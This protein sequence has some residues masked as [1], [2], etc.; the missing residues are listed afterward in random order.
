MARTIGWV[1]APADG[2]PPDRMDAY[3]VST[4]MLG[5]ILAAGAAPR[6]GRRTALQSRLQGHF[7]LL[8][9]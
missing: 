6:V 4:M 5:L 9:S 3:I 8:F 2:E 7:E 1:R